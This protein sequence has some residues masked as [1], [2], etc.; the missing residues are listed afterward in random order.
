MLPLHLRAELGG[1]LTERLQPALV[2]RRDRQPRRHR[3]D[4]GRERAREDHGPDGAPGP[5]DRGQWAPALGLDR[6]RLGRDAGEER[7]LDRGGRSH[8]ILGGEPRQAFLALAQGPQGLRVARTHQGLEPG[9]LVA[10]E[11]AK[12]IAGGQLQL[13]SSRFGSALTPRPP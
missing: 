1:L 10:L 3:G 8:R 6:P 13:I 9:A 7:G 2:A 4:A 12:S 5:L 11:R